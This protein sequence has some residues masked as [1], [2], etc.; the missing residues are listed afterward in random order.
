MLELMQMTE[1]GFVLFLIVILQNVICVFDALAVPGY[2][3]MTAVVYL[4]Y[5]LPSL[6]SLAS[7]GKT[8]RDGQMGNR[9][10]G[11]RNSSTTA[12]PP[13]HRTDES[14]SLLVRFNRCCVVRKKRFRQFYVIGIAVWIIYLYLAVKLRRHEDTTAPQQALLLYIRA[15]SVL[16]SVHLFRRLYECTYV[17]RWNPFSRMH[18]AGYLVGAMHYIWLPS[19]FVRLPCGECCLNKGGGGV[20]ALLPAALVRVQYYEPPSLYVRDPV[21]RTALLWRIAPIGLCL[22]GQYQQH[23]HHVLLANLRRNPQR[24]QEG[25]NANSKDKPP[26]P[27]GLPTEGWFRYVT[28]PHY[29]AE[30]LVYASF[31]ILLQQEQVV[32]GHRH[33]IVLIWV[34]SNLTMSAL[35]NFTWYKDN[36][37]AAVMKGRKAIIPLLL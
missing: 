13:K 36:L 32:Q 8:R 2:C 24:E 31:A 9:S 26:A 17:H 12:A 3:A 1:Q 5:L 33:F 29:L 35:I 23:R 16:L 10:I 18:V 34:I 7:H 6:T 21:L 27:Y 19:A 11:S 25:R 4:S 20:G 15:S 14:L 28:C 37:P 22:W 30:I